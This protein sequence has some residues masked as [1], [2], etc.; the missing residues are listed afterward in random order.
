M[1][2]F[3]LRNGDSKP[4]PWEKPR[5]RKKL[6]QRLDSLEHDQGLIAQHKRT[7][8]YS[9]ARRNP[10]V[11]VNTRLCALCSVTRKV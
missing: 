4:W 10:C 9:R 6:S 1:Y 2:Q 11:Q 7:L 3:R 8:H 5:E